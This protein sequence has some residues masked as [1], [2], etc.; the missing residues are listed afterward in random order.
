MKSLE[1]VQRISKTSQTISINQLVIKTMLTPIDK[2]DLSIFISRS[3]LNSLTEWAG[4]KLVI[5]QTVYCSPDLG[6]RSCFFSVFVRL[7]YLLS[8]SSLTNRVEGEWLLFFVLEMGSSWHVVRNVKS[9]QTQNRVQ[10]FRCESLKGQMCFKGNF[11]G[12]VSEI[13]ADLN[14]SNTFF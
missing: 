3:I 13:P 1:L 11:L 12:K 14:H 6:T 5:N 4:N 8:R 9:A 10:L 7:C 2:R